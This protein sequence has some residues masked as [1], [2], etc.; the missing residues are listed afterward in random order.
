MAPPL[1]EKLPDP[2]TGQRGWPWTEHSDPVPETQPGG[3][4]WPTISVVTPSY[5]Q[6]QFIEKTIRSVLLQGYPNLEYI[7]VDGGSTDKTVEILE[8]YDPW[9]DHWVSESDRGQSHAINKGFGCCDGEGWG[10]WINSDDWLAK[11]ALPVVGGYS[12]TRILSGACFIDGPDDTYIQQGDVHD[13]T[14]LLDIVNVWRDGDYIPQPATFFPLSTFEALGGLSE[15]EPYVMDYDLWCRLFTHH[16]IEYVDRPFAHFRFHEGQ[17]TSNFEAVTEHL[18]RCAARHL[19]DAEV[20]EET[21]RWLRRRI[22]EYDH[23]RWKKTG[24]LARSGLPRPLV[25]AIR[26]LAD[27]IGGS[28]A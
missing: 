17:K 14:A 9:I 11:G 16:E 3:D 12:P 2:P 21:R 19:D 25:E 15:E 10:G 1:L 8:K 20:E 24:R 26:T 18:R 13:L 7:V 22:E 23:Y 28:S 6:G 4:P 27:T 5:N